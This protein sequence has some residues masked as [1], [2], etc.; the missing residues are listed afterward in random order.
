[1]PHNDDAAALAIVIP[2]RVDPISKIINSELMDRQIGEYADY[3]CRKSR[4]RQHPRRDAT[5]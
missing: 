3:A 4:E 1:M 2:Q 5:R